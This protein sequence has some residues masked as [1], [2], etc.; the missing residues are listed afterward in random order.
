LTLTDNTTTYEIIPY[1]STIAPTNRQSKILSTGGLTVA[2]GTVT[3]APGVGLAATNAEIKAL[4]DMIF[5]WD[6]HPDWIRNGITRLL[7]NQTYEA[8]IPVTMVA[9]GDMEDTEPISASTGLGNWTEIGGSVVDTLE[10]T[11]TSYPF[12]F[13]R[14]ALHIDTAATSDGVTSASIDINNEETLTLAVFVKLSKGTFDVVLYDATNSAALK[15]VSLSETAPA[16]VAFTQSPSSTTKTVTVRFIPTTADSELHVGPVSLWSGARDRYAVD[17]SSVERPSDITAVYELP[18]GTSVET[19][20]YLPHEPLVEVPFEVERDD[21]SNLLNILVPNSSR[22]M[23]MKVAKRHAELALD[24]DTTYADRE[25]VVQ[26]VMAEI[27]E[28]RADRATSRED[29]ARHRENARRYRHTYYYLRDNDDQ[30]VKVIERPPDR[31]AVA[32]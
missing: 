17:T 16:V 13:G 23:F 24:T 18:L 20:V 9:D 6:L 29:R 26:G 3:I 12:L 22:P 25:M 5:C 1:S 31:T 15:T 7:R 32:M 8:Y 10:K 19:N 14:Q 2:T 28:M 4:T 11:S 30:F 27:E 21:R